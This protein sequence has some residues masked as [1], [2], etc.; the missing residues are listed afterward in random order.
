MWLNY[1]KKLS[2]GDQLTGKIVRMG[3]TRALVNIDGGVKHLWLPFKEISG[4]PM[5]AIAAEKYIKYDTPVIVEVISGDEPSSE[6][7]NDTV[8]LI[9]AN[10]KE[11]YKYD[12]NAV[13]KISQG[14]INKEKNMEMRSAAEKLQHGQQH[15]GVYGGRNVNILKTARSMNSVD[16]VAQLPNELLGKVAFSNDLKVQAASYPTNVETTTKKPAYKK[17]NSKKNSLDHHYKTVA[18]DLVKELNSE[19]NAEVSSDFDA[20]FWLRNRGDNTV[21]KRASFT[22]RKERKKK[23]KK[24]SEGMKRRRACPHLSKKKKHNHE[25][26]KNRRTNKRNTSTGHQETDFCYLICAYQVYYTRLIIGKSFQQ[27]KYNECYYITTTS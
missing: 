7:V 18:R 6:Q 26:Q 17:K 16:G 12:N 19:H 3:A 24:N 1:C 25:S 9:A 22:E 10:G 2:V 13:A 27:C 23:S 20:E 5:D 15:H 14:Y 4:V 8:K 21:K 11:V